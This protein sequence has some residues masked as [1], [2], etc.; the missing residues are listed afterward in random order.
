[1]HECWKAEKISKLEKQVNA[2]QEQFE[3]L[4]IAM[5]LLSRDV[6][7]IDKWLGDNK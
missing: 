5:E 3:V 7:V 1:M 4:T 2:L 6:E